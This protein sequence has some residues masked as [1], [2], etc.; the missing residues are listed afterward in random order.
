[1]PPSKFSRYRLCPLR[2]EPT[3]QVTLGERV[4][5]GYRDLADTIQHRVV[6]GDTL[7]RISAHYYR[8][9]ASPPSQFFWAIADFQP[10]PIHDPTIT[11]EPNTII[12]VPS[13]RTLREEILSERRRQEFEDGPA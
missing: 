9:V 11:L 5:F 12:L 13:V 7:H 10:T 2:L 4:P 8:G 3:G 1:M 6:A